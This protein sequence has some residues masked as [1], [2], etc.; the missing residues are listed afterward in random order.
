MLLRN[1]KQYDPPEEGNPRR[2]GKR[3]PARKG[4][5]Q[6]PKKVGKCG[7]KV[8]K[9]GRKGTKRTQ[10]KSQEK[11]GSSAASEESN[12]PLPVDNPNEVQED[13]RPPP[14]SPPPRARE[15]VEERA[16]GN[17]DRMGGEAENE[18][19]VAAAASNSSGDRRLPMAAEQFG[20]SI[21][22]YHRPHLL[23]L[24]HPIPVQ[25]VR[26][27][28]SG[29]WGFQL[30]PSVAHNG[31]R[32]PMTLQEVAAARPFGRGTEQRRLPN[33]LPPYFPY[34]LRMRG[35]NLPQML[36]PSR[37]SSTVEGRVQPSRAPVAD[38]EQSDNPA[39]QPGQPRAPGEP[40][41]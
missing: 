22:R 29:P 23:M 1:K 27:G 41:Q 6:K 34:W 24:S 37:A 32:R 35:I 31:V 26:A 2:N 17:P 15:G 20:R 4:G 25:V 13:V 14:P 8:S 38:A 7:R 12:I 16:P 19:R 21:V 10:Q 5:V 18:A 3:P 11:K 36:E 9:R 28:L 30:A 39:Q 33:H 40:Q